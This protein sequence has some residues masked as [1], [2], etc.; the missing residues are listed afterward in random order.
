MNEYKSAPVR[1]LKLDATGEIVA[2]FAQL[3]VIDSDGDVTLPGAF[4][5]KEVP[6]SAYGHT[7]WDGALPVGKGSIRE[8]GDWAIFTG[9]LFMSTTHGRDAYETLKG[10][11]S[12]AEFSYGYVPTD[13]SYGQQDGKQ[14][15]FLKALDV[16][17]VSNVLKGAGLGTHLRA[18]KSGAPEPG[19]SS[20]TRLVWYSDGMKAI[21]DQLTEHS[22]TRARDRRKLSRSD[23]AVLEDLV[24]AWEGHV[25]A[26]HALL[27]EATPVDP[28]K[29][30]EFAKAAQENLLAIA[31][32][33]GVQLG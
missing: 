13:F 1:D 28:A 19:A 7:S 2:A 11:G 29:Q 24:E 25:A 17:E 20:A 8:E 4:P 23:R 10:L 5:V 16:H 12:L 31:R 27:T 18:I 14:V 26:A 22:A 21:L 15:R 32:A 6:M 30:A 9:Q 3:N 33:N